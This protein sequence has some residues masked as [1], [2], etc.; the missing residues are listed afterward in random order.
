MQVVVTDLDGRIRGFLDDFDTLKLTPTING[1]ATVQIEGVDPL[2][3]G[4][5]ELKVAERALKVYDDSVTPFAL[6]FFGKVWEPLESGPGGRTVVARDPLAEF[7]WRRVRDPA[8]ATYTGAD[9]GDELIDRVARQNAIR[10]TYLRALTA[11]RQTSTAATRAWLA[12]KREDEIFNDVADANGSPFF[13]VDPVD[14]VAGVMG[15]LIVL[16]PNAG[17]TRE[18]VRFAYG[19]GTLDNCSDY[20]LTWTLPLNRYTASSSDADGG[21]IGQPFQ[22]QTSIDR[23]GLFEDETAYSD[24]T[25]TNLLASAAQAAVHAEPGMTIA[26]TPTLDAPLLYRDFNVGDFV[27]VRILYGPDDLF[28]WGRVVTATLTIDRDG[29]ERLEALT[30]DVLTGSANVTTPPEDLFRQRLDQERARLEAL[31][32]R[33]QLLQVTGT[34]TSVPPGGAGGEST[35][36]STEP[37][38]EPPAPPPPPPP[39]PPPAPSISNV[40][41]DAPTT[42]SVSL[43]ADVDGNGTYT[44]ATVVV[45]QGGVTRKI[46]G[47]IAIGAGGGH[48][49]VELSGLSRNTTYDV[50]IY[51]NSAAGSTSAG[52]T[53][54]TPNTD[55]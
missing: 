10:N 31:E 33:V 43:S 9:F 55:L 15:D 14:G 39:S 42:S 11:N 27:R 47:S 18:G 16:Y 52:G 28:T 32:R 54:T 45:S 26:V 34:G 44:E 24:T 21:R 25:D 12:G 30:V 1:Y 46:S 8:T 40:A 22:D 5:R 53:V 29:T 35:D 41:V 48:V 50:T 49:N 19:D 51:A 3:L 4:A 36:P 6:R 23:Y 37:P 13:R 17:A 7:A 38:P 2:S 20:K